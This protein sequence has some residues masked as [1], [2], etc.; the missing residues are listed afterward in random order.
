MDLSKLTPGDQVIGISGIVLF[1]FSFFEMHPA[2]RRSQHRACAGRREVFDMWMVRR[3][4]H[5]QRQELQPRLAF[6][7]W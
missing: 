3:F 5:P 1:I 6:A 4:R 2:E 7:K